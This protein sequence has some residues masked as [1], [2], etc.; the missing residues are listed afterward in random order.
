MRAQ[1]I[2]L[3]A[4]GKIDHRISRQ[5]AGFTRSDDPPNR[6]KPVPIQVVYHIV[7]KA[8][9]TMPPDPGMHAVADMTCI[10]YYYLMRPGEHTFSSNNTPFKIQDVKLYHQGTLV[11]W[12]LANQATLATVDSASLTFTTQKN[13]VKGEIIAHSCSGHSSVCPVKSLIRRLRY[14]RFL[15]SPLDAPLGRF[16][17]E[18][19]NRRHV[20]SKMVTMALRASLTELDPLGTKYDIK[21]QDIEARSLRAGGA[22]ALLCAGVDTDLIQLMGRWKSDAMIRYLHISAHPH[23]GS[24]A[25]KMFHAA[26]DF[27]PIITE[28]PANPQDDDE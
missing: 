27:V 8:W 20:T 16:Y 14:H 21:P 23:L 25:K 12:Q 5:L 11:D 4:H 22:T 26:Y 19:G 13:G 28:V 15:G 6:V 9:T 3:N 7:L 17:D 10:G 18:Q 24:F 1:D 2:R